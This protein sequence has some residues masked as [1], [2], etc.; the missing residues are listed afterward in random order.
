MQTGIFFGRRKGP[1]RGRFC[2]SGSA[3]FAAG[4]G[5]GTGPVSPKGIARRPF[6]EKTGTVGSCRGRPDH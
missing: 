2:A 5:F 3:R 1:A 4:K 6:F